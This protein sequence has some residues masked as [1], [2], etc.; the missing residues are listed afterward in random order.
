MARG[1]KR[2]PGR[3]GRRVSQQL[4]GRSD[5]L[6]PAID[7][8]GG[9]PRP[10][11]VK[12]GA[13][14]PGMEVGRPPDGGLAALT[15]MVRARLDRP[16]TAKPIHQRNI[17]LETNAWGP[18]QPRLMPLPPQTPTRTGRRFSIVS[19]MVVVCPLSYDKT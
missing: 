8:S 14:E 10:A 3:R 5:A 18:L 19:A 6:M 11:N 7:P 12:I 13:E 2:P 16:P 15:L 9:K 1:G 4:A 17:K